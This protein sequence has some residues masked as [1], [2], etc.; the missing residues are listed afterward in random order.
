MRF[1]IL[2][3]LQVLRDGEAVEPGSPKQRALLIDLLVHHGEVVSRD[4]LIEDLWAGSP[5]STGLGVLQNYISQLRKAL[6]RDVLVTRGPGYTLDIAP[7]D[8]DALRFDALVQEAA[9]A[10]RAGRADTAGELLRQAQA[11]WRGPALADVGGEAFA[12]PEIA[13][14]TELRAVAA[15]LEVE[16][17]LDAGQHREVVARLERLLAEHPFRERLWG[18]LMLALY[19]SGRQADAL[20]VYRK[21]RQLIVEE[22]GI[23][24]GAELRE[25]EM[26]ILRQRTEL[27]GPRPAWPAPAASPAPI[28]D[29]PLGAGQV[30]APSLPFVGRAEERAL[31]S[32]FVR[33]VRADR[34]HGLLLLQ[35]EPGIGKTRLLTEL[36]AE[37]SAAGG[38]VLCGRAY[39]AERGRPYG[40]WIDAVRSSPLLPPLPDRVR[41]DLTPLLPELSGE[42]TVLEDER[43]L[44]DAV[45]ALLG[46]LGAACPLVV[47]L[48]DI[49]WLD[50][51]SAGLLHFAVRALAGTGIVFAGAA[52]SAEL[53]VNATVRGL[54]RDLDRQGQ[55]LSTLVP[56]LD[57][58]LDPHPDRDGRRRRRPVPRCGGQQRQPAPRRRD[59]SGSGPWRGPRLR[60]G[61]R[62]HR[63]PSRRPRRRRRL[64]RSVDGGLRA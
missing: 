55:L 57:P 41:S 35:G 52:R 46:I 43:R 44:Y 18:L 6:G 19:R 56:P 23:E 53:E 38:R 32:A 20:R 34:R 4:R 2:G 62:P 8:L 59:G 42:P 22:L 10:R 16:V 13:R 12:L 33:D 30:P 61:R 60:T 15:E 64:A 28:A 40:A 58:E 63:R 25:L 7:D 37:V 26:A 47:L 29:V 9:A 31:M 21:A 14:L 36:G 50:E 24:P 11:L 45:G 39:E 27:L 1:A 51:A 3:P 48:D 49:Q 54:V 17:G 5:P